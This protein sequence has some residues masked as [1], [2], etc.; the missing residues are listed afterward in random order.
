MSN[1][2]EHAGKA[3]LC[4]RWLGKSEPVQCRRLREGDIGPA[5]LLVAQLCQIRGCSGEPLN[6]A[7][8]DNGLTVLPG[9]Q[10]QPG[11][12]DVSG[13][14]T[15]WPRVTAVG[16]SSIRTAMR[17]RRARRL[18]VPASGSGDYSAARICSS[19]RSPNSTQSI[20]R[21]FDSAVVNRIGNGCQPVAFVDVVFGSKMTERNQIRDFRPASNVN[22]NVN[23]NKPAVP[24][25]DYDLPDSSAVGVGRAVDQDGQ[26][27]GGT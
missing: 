15:A 19:R 8:V 4:T 27:E 1:H 3:G 9:S 21:D 18:T 24:I 14:R 2:L 12:A 20:E 7:V 17:W 11:V 22:V 13:Y 23:V 25:V 10:N 6:G 26:S 16:M 5:R